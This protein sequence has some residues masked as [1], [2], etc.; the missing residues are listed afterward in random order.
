MSDSS[1]DLYNL[2]QQ[3]AQAMETIETLSESNQQ[4]AHLL[5]HI[6]D[7]IW[8]MNKQFDITWISP[9]VNNILGFTDK[10]LIKK[11]LPSFCPPTTLDLIRKAIDKRTA[12]I[13]DKT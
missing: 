9:S 13:N 6:N 10:M 2:K 8:V 5:N 1:K 7:F 12:D 3:L 11:S 4:Y